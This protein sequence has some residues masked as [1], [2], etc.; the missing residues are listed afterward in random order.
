MTEQEDVNGNDPT[1]VAPAPGSI[2]PTN[3]IESLRQQNSRAV[4]LPLTRQVLF[5]HLRPS[6]WQAGA[7]P[8]QELLAPREN[9]YGVDVDQLRWRF[10]KRPPW[11]P[12][13]LATSVNVTLRSAGWF[14]CVTLTGVRFLGL[15]DTHHPQPLN[16]SLI[17]RFDAMKGSTM[18][19]I[20]QC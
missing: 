12:I 3:C 8:Q 20:P 18:T 19:A 7:L 10:S 11:R 6:A 14:D 17:P 13:G 16:N 1:M 9:S 4:A 2:F 15:A 5:S